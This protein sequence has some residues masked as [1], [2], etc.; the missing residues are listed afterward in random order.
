MAR[1]LALFERWLEEREL[2]L[3]KLELSLEALATRGRRRAVVREITAGDVVDGM[4]TG[5]GKSDSLACAEAMVR[6]S[7]G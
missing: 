1:T 3:A 7:T 2:V 5:A 4:L 6:P